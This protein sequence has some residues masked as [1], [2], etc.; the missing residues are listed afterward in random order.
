MCMSFL[1][2]H[3]PFGIAEYAFS[4]VQYE[5]ATRNCEYYGSMCNICVHSSSIVYNVWIA[6]YYNVTESEHVLAWQLLSPVILSLKLRLQH[7]VI[8]S[9]GARTCCSYEVLHHGEDRLRLL[10]KHKD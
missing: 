9:I 1:C 8:T 5:N 6:M 4:D 3:T 10:L 2:C 7:Y